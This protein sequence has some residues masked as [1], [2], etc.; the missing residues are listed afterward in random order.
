MLKQTQGPN[1]HFRAY[2]QD[3]S[4]LIQ[5]VIAEFVHAYRLIYDIKNFVDNNLLTAQQL[6]GSVS[7]LFHS[8]NQLLGN[9]SNQ[10]HAAISKWIKGPLTKMKEYCEQFSHNHELDKSHLN[11]HSA[12]YQTWLVA[13]H[14][15][16]LINTFRLCRTMTKNISFTSHVQRSLKRLLSRFNIVTKQ[17]P[18]VTNLYWDNENVVYF[19]MKR[20]QELIDIYGEEEVNKYFKSFAKQAVLT[21]HL[22]RRYQARG[23]THPQLEKAAGVNS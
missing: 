17:I 4:V 12:V 11:L 9:Q 22:I 20:K 14:N 1:Q 5:L 16:D 15:M 8:L 10:E 13:I 18:R 23:F 2:Y 7:S 21:P 19:L 6:D 3:N